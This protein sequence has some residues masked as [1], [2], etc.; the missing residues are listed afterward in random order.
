MRIRNY[1]ERT[2]KTYIS[3]IGQVTQYY[4]LPPSQVT[5][6]QFKAHLY[7]LVNKENC[8]VSKINQNISA[9]KILQQDILNRKW[10][11]IRI[12]RP[13]KE[14][15]LPVV[16]SISEA[17]AL[18]NA[19]NNQ[20]HRILITLVY[21]TGVRRNELLNITL[22]DIDRTREVIKIRGKGNKQREV[23]LSPH[24]LNL[25]ESYYKRYR[26]SVFLFE[27]YVP[28]KSYSAE[29]M[30]NIV[31][32][33]TVK[34]GIKKNI[35]PHVLRHSFATHMLEKGVNLKRL[36]ILLGHNSMKTTSIYLHLADIDKVQ[37]P[38]LIAD[39]D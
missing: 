23:P 19:P 24:L 13:R 34:A 33:A 3:A 9:W 17:K 35:S 25:L 31:K 16:L 38:D 6:S 1:S 32:N 37:L 15:K 27:G 8:S 36:Q 12:K 4:N 11:S 5:T 7:H 26:P 21:A 14:K 2:I 28:G 10:D 20:K 30:T 29:S 22:K 18:V 39:I